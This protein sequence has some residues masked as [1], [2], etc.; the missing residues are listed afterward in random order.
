[1]N[2]YE[3][4]A[5]CVANRADTTDEDM[6]RCK[7]ILDGMG[8][9][10]ELERIYAK[11]SGGEKSLDLYSF[12]K[13]LDCREETLFNILFRFGERT[14]SGSTVI[15]PS[16]NTMNAIRQFVSITC[17]SSEILHEIQRLIE[18]KG[19]TSLQKIVEER[20]QGV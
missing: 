15:S 10:S 19:R 13:I 18:K 7:M 2:N 14:Y 8:S 16:T 20:I 1:M 6:R 3:F 17:T 5:K 11:M 4:V 12:A 9:K